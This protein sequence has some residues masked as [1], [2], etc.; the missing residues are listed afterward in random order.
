[1]LS[2]TAFFIVALA[3]AAC[4]G[5]SMAG[6]GGGDDDRM[7]SVEELQAGG[8]WELVQ[9]PGIG[10][11]PATN[12][13]SLEFEVEGRVGGRTGCNQFGGE[14]TRTEDALTFGE[15]ISTK[16][17]CTEGNRMEVEA[18]FVG[19]LQNT[20]GATLEE[21]TLTLVSADGSV[22]ARLVSTAG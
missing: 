20:R 22:L 3:V 15:L 4:G 13:P 5:S 17:A 19:A 1:M 6:G 16:M 18:A 8:V 2:K 21:R 12:R 9:L 11:L 10:A 7:P 14:F